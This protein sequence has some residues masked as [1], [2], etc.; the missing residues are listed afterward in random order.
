MWQRER[1]RKCKVLYRPARPSKHELIHRSLGLDYQGIET[2]Q[3]KPEGW[4]S[5]A[6]IFH[7]YMVTI[8]YDPSVLMMYHQT[9]F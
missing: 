9:D 8:I 7:T 4:D 5:I 6:V 3:I 2:L 1:S